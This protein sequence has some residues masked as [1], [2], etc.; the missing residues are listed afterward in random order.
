MIEIRN[1]SKLKKFYSKFPSEGAL[2]ALPTAR[3][4][5]DK[6]GRRQAG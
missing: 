4:S 2:L 3:L 6:A 5:V 1:V